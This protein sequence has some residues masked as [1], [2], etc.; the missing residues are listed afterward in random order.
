MLR[1]IYICYM[2]AFMVAA[3]SSSI[4]T[5]CTYVPMVPTG[6]CTSLNQQSWGM[7]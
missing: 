4:H 6:Q 5:R 7:A 1:S 3:S 2:N